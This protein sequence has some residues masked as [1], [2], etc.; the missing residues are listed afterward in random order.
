M[1]QFLI[2]AKYICHA[3]SVEKI[4]RPRLKSLRVSRI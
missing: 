1:S 4:N 2:S 3:I